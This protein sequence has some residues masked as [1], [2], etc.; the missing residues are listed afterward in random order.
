MRLRGPAPPG[1]RR[2]L[3][4][5]AACDAQREGVGLRDTFDGMLDVCSRS[6]RRRRTRCTCSTSTPLLRAGGAGARALDA[7]FAAR[8][9]LA[10]AMPGA[11]P[12]A[13][14][15]RGW[16]RRF[17]SSGWAARRRLRC[18]R[19]I[20]AYLPSST[21][22]SATGRSG[23]G[24]R[25]SRRSTGSRPRH[26]AGVGIATGNVAEGARPLSTARPD[27]ALCLR[28]LRLRLGAPAPVVAR[29]SSACVAIAGTCAR[30]RMVVVA[31][32][33][34]T[35]RRRAPAASGWSRWRPARSRARP[36]RRRARCGARHLADCER[37]TRTPVRRRSAGRTLPQT[38]PA[39]PRSSATMARAR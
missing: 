39:E 14:P 33:S 21:A 38:A 30:E 13:A 36:R 32:P 17:S 25:W 10:G 5:P 7:V 15:I 12:A 34:T 2:R 35:S 28:R 11:T 27:R 1:V 19:V 29:R 16:S 26:R 37:G 23:C 6:P 18:R 22:S 24:R 3:T 4:L 31:T 20:A 8:Y 9:Q